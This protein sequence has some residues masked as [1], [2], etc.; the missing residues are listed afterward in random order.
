MK[1]KENERAEKHTRRTITVQDMMV[2][3]IIGLVTRLQ[4]VKSAESTKGKKNGAKKN[5]RKNYG[6]ITASRSKIRSK[7]KSKIKSRSRKS[8]GLE[9]TTMA[10]TCPKCGAEKDDLHASP[11]YECGSGDEGHG[12]EQSDYCNLLER[13]NELEEKYQR[14]FKA[15]K[16]K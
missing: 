13:H 8:A 2:T 6:L 4:S 1:T 14:P 5:G 10:D 16:R 9:E 12:L 15:A 3:M 7:I 11:H